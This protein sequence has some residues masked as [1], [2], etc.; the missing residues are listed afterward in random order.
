MLITSQAGVVVM[1]NY[2]DEEVP[3]NLMDVVVMVH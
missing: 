3:V 1:V 2:L